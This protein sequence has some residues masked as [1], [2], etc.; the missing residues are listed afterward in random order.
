MNPLEKDNERLSIYFFQRIILSAMTKHTLSIIFFLC[1]I[2][3]TFSQT[4]KKDVVIHYADGSVFNGVII[5]ESITSLFVELITSD[6]VE[7]KKLLI[8]KQL[9][10]NHIIKTKKGKYHKKSGTFATFEFGATPSGDNG[11]AFLDLTVGKRILPNLNVGLGISRTHFSSNFA[12]SW[13]DG[14]FTNIFAYGKYYLNDK[15][16]RLFTDLKVG[17]GIPQRNGWNQLTTGFYAQPGFGVE[18]ANS[19]KLKWSFKISQYIQNTTTTQNFN[20]W[21]PWNSQVTSEFQSNLW[22]NRTTLSV[23]L[24]F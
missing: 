4:E 19:K 3:I 24:N 20:N 22:L 11:T 16:F 13:I 18:I 9:D 15:N 5:D 14:D 6:T 17:V 8:T 10:G 21:A 1:W 12:G 2:T 23:G 7:L